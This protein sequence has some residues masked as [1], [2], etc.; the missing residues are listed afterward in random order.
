MNT[1]QEFKDKKYVHLKNFLSKE[2]CEIL[3]NTL[4]GL[5][6]ENKTSPDSQCPL[7]QSI[8]G[9]PV[10]D[11]L[12]EDLTPYFESASGLKLYPTYAYA[13]L[14][15]PND[16]LEVHVD[17]ESCEI[18]ATVTLG[19]DGD[20]WSIY[21]GDNPDKSNATEIKMDI[22]DAVLYKGMEKWHW[23]EKYVEGKWQAQVFLHYVQQDGL[24]ADFKYDKRP[25]LSHHSLN[26]SD[27]YYFENAISEGFCDTLISEYTKDEVEKDL[28]YITQDAKLVDLTVRNVLRVNLP[29]NQGIG[30][31]LTSFGLNTNNNVWKFNVTHSNQTEF[32]IYGVDGKYVAHTDTF[33]QHSDE[34][35]KI[36]A[37]AILNDDFEG[38]KFFIQTSHEKVYP[39][40]KKG[41]VIIFP[42]FMM[43]GVEPVTKGVRHSVVTWLVGPYFK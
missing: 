30:A 39:P 25:K 8:H 9:A 7:S 11:K 28:P 27:F 38:G 17:R 43:H 37:L 2:N 40:Q 16:E 12:L 4:K 18:S 13:R 15:S 5:V 31:T 36:T 42:S 23:R 19:F 22:G 34:T 10:F 32:L 35:R 1:R 24:Y 3:T 26:F 21:M 33:H 20:V 6:S 14:Y 29:M 41:T